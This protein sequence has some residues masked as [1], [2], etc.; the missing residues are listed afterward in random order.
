VRVAR[1][2]MALVMAIGITLSCNDPSAPNDSLTEREAVALLRQLWNL[3]D[4]DRRYVGLHK[5]Q[6]PFRGSVTSDITVDRRE[7]GDT[8]WHSS[9]NVV[10]PVDCVIRA[11]ANALTTN[12]D[13]SMT[14]YWEHEFIR[15]GSDDSLLWRTTIAFMGAVRWTTPDDRTGICGMDLKLDHAERDEDNFELIGDLKGLLCGA[16]MVIH[17][18]ELR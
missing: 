16:D 6:C 3:S 10:T 2:S 4:N 12:G 5:Q 14:I 15:S 7:H 18:S 13:P 17:L 9:E 8:S 1:N 11:G